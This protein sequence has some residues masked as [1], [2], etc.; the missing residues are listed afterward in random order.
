MIFL[1]KKSVVYILQAQA[2]GETWEDGR[3]ETKVGLQ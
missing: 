2:I 1:F 3:N